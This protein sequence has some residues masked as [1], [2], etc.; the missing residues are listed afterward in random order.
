[1]E[2]IILEYVLPLSFIS[3]RYCSPYSI[4]VLIWSWETPLP[5]PAA[6]SL[7]SFVAFMI[8]ERT[9]NHIFMRY[10]LSYNCG[11]L[12]ILSSS[13][14]GKN[15]LPLTYLKL[16]IV[17]MSLA[18][19]PQIWVL[20]SYQACIQRSNFSPKINEIQNP[21]KILHYTKNCNNDLF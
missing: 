12:D 21:N 14:W 3:F 5:S 18:L 1:M 13:K 7:M 6:I 11:H 19:L 10:M 8:W 17:L 20:T 9:Y 2:K 4:E 15:F 16:L